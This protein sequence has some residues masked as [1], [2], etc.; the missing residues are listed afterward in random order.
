MKISVRVSLLIR[1][2]YPWDVSPRGGLLYPF[3]FSCIVL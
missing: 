1:V 2:A 3:P